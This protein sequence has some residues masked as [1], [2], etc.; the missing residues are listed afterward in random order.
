VPSLFVPYS[1]FLSFDRLD[2]PDLHPP[3]KP[4]HFDKSADTIPAMTAVLPRLRTK[5]GSD[6]AYFQTVYNHTFEFA[7]QAGQ[8]SISACFLRFFHSFPIA[9]T[10]VAGLCT[11]AHHT[12]FYVLPTTDG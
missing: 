12:H 9:H 5:L 3:D 2:R 1:L 11:V 4:R 6:P 10:F 8:R 7:K